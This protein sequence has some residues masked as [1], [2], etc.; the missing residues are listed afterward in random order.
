MSTFVPG[1]GMILTFDL[2]KPDAVSLTLANDHL[3]KSTSTWSLS[4]LSIG[5][6]TY[7]DSA[8]VHGTVPER[9]GPGCVT[10]RSAAAPLRSAVGLRHGPQSLVPGRYALTVSGNVEHGGMALVVVGAG[11]GS[12][13]PVGRIGD[14]LP[15]AG[16][17]DPTLTFTLRSAAAVRLALANNAP[18][19]GVRS[20]WTISQVALRRTGPA[21]P[22]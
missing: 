16:N 13:I 5:A 19:P 8:G 15:G 10:G 3:S 14:D 18:R 9:R 17:Q 7:K 20:H 6:S 2:K 21:A 22:P 1:R 11:N 4:S 12:L